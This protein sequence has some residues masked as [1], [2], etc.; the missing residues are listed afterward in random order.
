MDSKGALPMR[1]TKLQ[2]AFAALFLASMVGCQ[3]G[4][5][6][7]RWDWWRTASNAPPDM[8]A[9]A[10]SA[11]QFPELPSAKATPDTGAG[12]AVAST[13]G[14]NQPSVTGVPGYP[15]T[16]SP[17]ATYPSSAYPTTA[18]FD[19]GSQSPSP[20]TSPAAGAV[21]NPTGSA[22][23]YPTTL[24]SGQSMVPNRGG[25]STIRPQSTPYVPSAAPT[26]NSLAG[27]SNP[28]GV[29]SAAGPPSR[30][31]SGVSGLASAG[32]SP[33]KYSP[34]SSSSSVVLPTPPPPVNGR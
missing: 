15:A 22:G 17:G 4:M 19:A 23:Q 34:S 1:L 9:L 16:K 33:A 7:P 11:P 18:S 31:G 20:S 5:N 24:A 27:A 21:T 3:S 12:S 29:N 32:G 25:T 6:W 28:S 13:T 8:S 14:T 10:R 2:T 30:Y 26:P